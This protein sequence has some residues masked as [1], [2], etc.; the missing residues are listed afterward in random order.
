M[1][2]V[3]A[4]RART[5]WS[6]WSRNFARPRP[7]FPPSNSGKSQL[8]KQIDAAAK[9]RTEEARRRELQRLARSTAAIARRDRTALAAA[10]A[11][12]GRAGRRGRRAG[13]RANGRGRT[14]RAGQG[15]CGRTPPEGRRSPPRRWPKPAASLP[16][17]FAKPPPSWPRSNLPGWQDNVKHLRRQQEN[18]LDEAQRLRGLEES[19]GQLTR[20]QA[21]SVLELARLQR[22][23]QTDA[24]QLGQQLS[25]AGAFELA[26]TGAADDMGRGRRVARSA[27][28][29]PAHARTAA[30]RAPPARSVGRGPETRTA[31]RAESRPGGQR[32]RR[33]QRR[34]E[35]RP[36]GR[37]PSGDRPIEAPEADAAGDQLPHRDLAAGGRRQAHARATARVRCLEPTARPSGRHRAAIGR[38]RPSGTPKPPPEV[39][40]TY[41]HGW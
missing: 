17:S 37:P 18:A 20:S 29:R 2:D 34:Q 24:A 38:R 40:P 15:D 4:N 21:L 28:D 5:S 36:A 31:R 9:D 25:A 22:S 6:A 27:R 14:S 26:L 23:L 11:I 19:Q 33:Q 8:R 35:A 7:I 41:S 10:C 13:R 39:K 3:L 30:P 16:S 1:L 12:A 32:R